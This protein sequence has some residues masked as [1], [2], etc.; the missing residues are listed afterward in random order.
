MDLELDKI[1]GNLGKTIN[2]I[3]A[4]EF[5]L[6]FEAEEKKIT[7]FKDGRAIIKGIGNTGAAKSFYT[8]CLGL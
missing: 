6:K 8:R 7:L 2:N 3:M 4:S 1:A 5:L